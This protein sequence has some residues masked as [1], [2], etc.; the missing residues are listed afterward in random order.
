MPLALY[1]EDSD[2]TEVYRDEQGQL[3][4]A[5]GWITRPATILQN[6]KTGET[7]VEVIGCPN[8]ER[9]TQLIEKP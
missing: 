6:I 2:H 8:A 7:L 9:F 5:V 1:T 3:W 4:Q